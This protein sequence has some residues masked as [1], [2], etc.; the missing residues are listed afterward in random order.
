[1]GAYSDEDFTG[2]TFR[3]SGRNPPN[4]RLLDALKKLADPLGPI[5][6]VVSPSDVYKERAGL[7]IAVPHTERARMQAPGHIERVLAPAR[8]VPASEAIDVPRDRVRQV[9]AFIEECWAPVYQR[10][11]STDLLTILRASETLVGWNVTQRQ[12]ASSRARRKIA[13]E[14]FAEQVTSL[15][16]QASDEFYN[17]L[18]P[19]VPGDDPVLIDGK[20]LRGTVITKGR[21]EYEER[22]KGYC[23]WGAGFVK[24]RI[25]AQAEME[26]RPVRNVARN[27]ERMKGEVLPM[28][29]LLA[30]PRR[31]RRSAV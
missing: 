8:Y 23:H 31:D 1:M 3:P 18:L 2:R 30:N 28:R 10:T 14:Q 7:P 9:S 29:R 16:I 6:A 12:S 19:T 26:S 4:V 5:G 24:E 22:T 20:L 25:A 17:G 21:A 27:L 13:A 15:Q 11:D